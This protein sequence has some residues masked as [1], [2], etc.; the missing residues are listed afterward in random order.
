LLVLFEDVLCMAAN[1]DP[2]RAI[3]FEGAVS[4]LLRLTTA[5]GI[6]TAGPAAATLPLHSFEIS[7]VLS[8]TWFAGM[9]ER[10]KG[11]L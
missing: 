3:G 1:L 11:T 8:V 2:I 6:T 10:P 4:V 7:H 5:A 9:P